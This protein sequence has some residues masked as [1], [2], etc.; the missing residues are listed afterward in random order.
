MSLSR[1]AL[2]AASLATPF[3]GPLGAAEPVGLTIPLAAEPGGLIAGVSDQPATRLV[4]SKIYQ[5]LCRFSPALQPSPSLSAS[6]EISHDGL[7]Y[8]FKLAPNV[9]WHDGE[10]FTADDVVFSLDRFHRKLS[11]R[12]GP[13]LERMASVEAPDALTVVVKLTAPFEPFLLLLDALSTPIVPK[14]IHDRPGFALDPRQFP[15]IGTGPFRHAEWLRLVRFDGYVG[16]KTALDEIV[17]PIQPAL[18]GRL[19][20]MQSG[21]PVLMVAGGADF[22]AIPRLHDT[23]GLVVAG[24]A[25][26][27]QA[28]LAW[29]EVN[30]HAKPLDDTRVRQALAA[31][32][33]RAALLQDIWLG[34]GQVA[35][36]PVASATR[37]HDPAAKLPAFD[38]RAAS[39][40][41]DAAGLRPDEQGLRARIRHLVP[42]GEPWRSLA[43]SLHTALGLVGVELVLEPVD[44]VNDWTRR[45]AAGAYETTAMVAEQRGDPALDIAQF[46]LANTAGYANPAVDALLAQGGTPDVRRAAFAQ[47]QKLLIDDMAQIWLVEPT[48]PVARD[49]RVTTPNGVYGSFDDIILGS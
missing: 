27:N 15:P 33:D 5:G 49:H 3:A 40:Q 2:L 21:K 6:C 47:A 20:V 43:E 9:I 4:G 7:T 8:T 32:I 13:D 22:I 41:L 42:P 12:V 11:P 34:F 25:T 35:T 46:Y 23:P 36:S 38:L 17:F 29:F 19:A 14:H 28:M 18:D 24:E 31:S 10:A 1:R 16:P 48:L 30:H 39:E 44:D 45:V 37:Y 26:T